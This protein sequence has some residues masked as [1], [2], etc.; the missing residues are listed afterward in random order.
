MIHQPDFSRIELIA[1]SEAL[2][3]AARNNPLGKLAQPTV[4]KIGEAIKLDLEREKAE[5]DA[6]KKDDSK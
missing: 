6:Q 1:I 4:D 3:A 5:S 2:I